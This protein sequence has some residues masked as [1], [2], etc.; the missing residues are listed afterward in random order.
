MEGSANTRRIDQLVDLREATKKN[1]REA[2]EEKE[3]AEQAK[4]DAAKAAQE[5]ADAATKAQADAAAKAQ[6]EEATKAQADAAAKAQAG[7]AAD[8]QA[9][10]LVIPLRS[11]PPASKILAPT[12]A[13]G[14]DQPVME[15]EGGEAVV[16]RAEVPQQKPAAETQ[17]SRPNAPSPKVGG[18]LVVGATPVDRTPVR[19]RAAKAI[20]APRPHEIGASSSSAP[21]AEATSSVLREWTTGG[22]TSVLNKAAHEVHSLLQAQGDALKDYIASCRPGL[23]Q[24]SCGRYNSHV[25]ELAKQT[26]ELTDSQRANATLRQQMGEAQTA[27]HAKEEE[28]LKME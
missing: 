28:R 26:A 19:R 17:G 12:R 13:A 7:G 21:E 8:G 3:R 24:H 2:R 9:P 6:E 23:P 15:R 11:M 1:A 14:N 18:G 10:Q 27:L 20:S 4:A 5:E 22:G 25:Q 16:P